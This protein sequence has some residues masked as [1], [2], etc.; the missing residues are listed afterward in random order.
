MHITIDRVACAGAGTCA[1]TAPTVFGIDDDYLVTLLDPSPD[2]SVRDEVEEAVLFCPHQALS[3][4]D[5]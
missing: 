1:A 2:E 4:S 5:A 3:V